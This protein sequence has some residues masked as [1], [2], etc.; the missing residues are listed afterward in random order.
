MAETSMI[1]FLP[2]GDAALVVELGE[3]VDESINRRVLAL[4][5]RLAALALDGVI[6][7][8]PTYRSLLVHY[9]PDR[10]DHDTLVR[11]I[12]TLARDLDVDGAT[13]GRLWRV[14]VA[15]GGEFGI[16]LG[17]V[18]AHHGLGEDE[19]ICRHSAAEYRV[20]MIGFSPGFAY[21]GGLDPGLYISRRASPRPLI[22]AGSV[23]IGGQQAAINSVDAPSGWHILGRTP[24]RLFHL[25]REPPFIF[26]T[27][28][29]LRFEPIAHERYAP[30]A[31][32]AE[33]G[34]LVADLVEP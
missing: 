3:T 14:P 4:D 8:V 5:R 15:Y 9:A 1:R 12:G 2:A 28:D 27:G 31:R 26:A 18:A 20:Y 16:D 7:C 17:A 34:A 23:I 24:A 13:R 32:A 10:I 21:L 33:A 29:R 11:E 25:R 6:E 30:L 22:A 19:V